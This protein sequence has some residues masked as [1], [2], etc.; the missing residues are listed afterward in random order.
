MLA[1]DSILSTQQYM[2]SAALIGKY[3]SVTETMYRGKPALPGSHRTLA[4][5]S[6]DTNG[7]S[8][9]VGI[10]NLLQIYPL[11]SSNRKLELVRPQPCTVEIH[12][13]Y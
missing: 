10:V 12:N 5:L 4:A 3:P 13:R 1:Y 8:K 7:L 6:Q 2:E 11:G 9:K